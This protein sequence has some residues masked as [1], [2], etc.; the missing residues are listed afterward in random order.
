ML[1]DRNAP[2]AGSP[3]VSQTADFKIPVPDHPKLPF[4]AHSTLF[5]A[6]LQ[7]NSK[8]EDK[9]TKVKH[10]LKK[11]APEGAACVIIQ[12]KHGYELKLNAQ[13]IKNLEPPRI[14]LS[15]VSRFELAAHRTLIVHVK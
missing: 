11:L 15:L 14:M 8:K 9:P 5:L 3:R 12:D 13:E 10:L 6:A 7:E 2:A 4:P 1:H